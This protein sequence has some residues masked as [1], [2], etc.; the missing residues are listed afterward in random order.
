M[1][2]DWDWEG[3]EKSFRR[4]IELNP[5]YPT[6]YH[7]YAYCL[8]A[9]RKHEE[10]IAA[11]TRAHELDPLSLIIS[12]DVAEVRYYARQY[13]RAIEQARRTL[14]MDPAFPLARRVLG[15]ALQERLGLILH[16]VDPHFDRLR[17]HP[18]FA[19]LLRQMRLPG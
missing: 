1:H 17:T 19:A 7:W 4:A 11:I 9:T 10:A 12:T 2:Y 6:A 5:S 13:D 3:A 16:A 15:W 8:T 14:E 18:R